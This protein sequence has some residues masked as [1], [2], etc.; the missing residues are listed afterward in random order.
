M[1]IN[2]RK[3]LLVNNDI[4]KMCLL[5]KYDISKLPENILLDNKHTF[6]ILF[7]ENKFLKNFAK[8]RN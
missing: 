8:D 5:L 6:K 2:K 1:K 4:Q 3:T 7:K